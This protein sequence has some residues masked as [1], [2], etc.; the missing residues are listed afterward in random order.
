MVDFLLLSTIDNTRELREALA[1]IRA[2]YGEILSVKKIYFSDWERGTID[3]GQVEEAVKS[4]WVILV[5]IRGQTE[6]TDRLRE[7]VTGSAATVVVLVGGGRDILSLTRMGSFSGADL[8]R[9]EGRFDIEVYL[10]ARK[11][12]ELTKKLGSVIPVGKLKHMRNWLLACEYYAEGGKE[13]LKNLFLFLLREYCRVKVDA[14]PPQKMPDW[15]IWWPPHRHFTDLKTFKTSVGWGEDK[16]AVGIFFYGGMHF[17]DCVPVVEALVKELR[18]EV[19]LIPVFSKVEHNLTAFRSCFF[20]GERPA[21]DLVVNLQYFRLH[22]G[23]F[24]GAPEPTYRLRAELVVPGR[25][26]KQQ[27]GCQTVFP[28]LNTQSPMQG[29]RLD[30]ADD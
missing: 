15:G 20:D 3:P 9:R 23:P 27:P 12:M 16:P 18:D 4:A 1:E 11:F 2:E 21:V 29:S 22:G 6:F 25:T 5:D 26:C 7:L 30:S 8:P 24:G 10:K 14:R 19:N 17:T 13:N 28:M